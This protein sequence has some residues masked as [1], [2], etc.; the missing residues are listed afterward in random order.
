[1]AA[2]FGTRPTGGTTVS[3]TLFGGPV[4]DNQLI[5]DSG[6]ISITPVANTPTSGTITFAKT[7]PSTPLVFIT[8]NT[9][10]PGTVVTGVS[11]N[12][13]S[14]TGATGWVTRTNT[15]ATTLQWF[16]VLTH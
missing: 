3:T 13:I 15:T 4:W 16:A 12:S 8:A 10:V 6:S 11:V 5:A 2:T 7:F 1:M 14:T 9:S